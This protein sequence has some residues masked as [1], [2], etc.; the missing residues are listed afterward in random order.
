MQFALQWARR[1]DRAP[2]Y[3]FLFSVR[4]LCFCPHCLFRFTLCVACARPNYWFSSTYSNLPYFHRVKLKTL[5]QFWANY[6]RSDIASERCSFLLWSNFLVFSSLFIFGDCCKNLNTND[7]SWIGH[8]VAPDTCSSLPGTL[9]SRIFTISDHVNLF[10]SDPLQTYFIFVLTQLALRTT[11]Q[12]VSSSTEQSRFKSWRK[13]YLPRVH[14][15]S[16]CKKC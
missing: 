11:L 5:N 1:V 9:K 13:L 4:K 3:F 8:K 2:P 7:S 14:F 12:M 16:S 10:H 6:S 15:I